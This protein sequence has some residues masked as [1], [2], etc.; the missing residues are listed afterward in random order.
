[1]HLCKVARFCA[2][3]HVLAF[4]VVRFLLPKWPAKKARISAKLRRNAIPPLVIPPF[5]CHR[6]VTADRALELTEMGNSELRS[7]CCLW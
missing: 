2:F 6:Q 4:F 1:M 3:L 7:V 5:A